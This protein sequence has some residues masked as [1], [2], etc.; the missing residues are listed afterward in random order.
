MTKTYLNCCSSCGKFLKSYH[1]K[2][3][4]IYLC[5]CLTNR[6]SIHYWTQ[7]SSERITNSRPFVRDKG[8]AKCEA[9]QREGS[10]A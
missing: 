9:D 5:S 6:N 2:L 7:L 8:P 1:P 3:Y 10:E 4:D